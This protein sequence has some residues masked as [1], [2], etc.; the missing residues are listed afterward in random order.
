VFGLDDAAMLLFTFRDRSEFA[1]FAATLS[2]RTFSTLTKCH[3][4]TMLL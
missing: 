3:Y 2:L 4:S 1:G